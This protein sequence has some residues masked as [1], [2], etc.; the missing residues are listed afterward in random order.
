MQKLPAIDGQELLKFLSSMGFVV[1]RTRGSHLQLRA[2]DRQEHH[3]SPPRQK[4]GS[5]RPPLKDNPRGFGVSLEEFLE[6]YSGY[7][8]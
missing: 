4:R 7:K 8:G 6:L 2:Q 5:Q 3:Y 1:V